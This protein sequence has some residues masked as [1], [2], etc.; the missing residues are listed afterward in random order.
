M[1]HWQPEEQGYRFVFALCPQGSRGK[2]LEG[3]R[4]PSQTAGWHLQAPGEGNGD[5]LGSNLALTLFLGFFWGVGV[6]L[7]VV[8]R[9]IPGENLLL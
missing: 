3:G 1:S 9:S 7:S 2:G 8:Q 6:V 5:F 4:L